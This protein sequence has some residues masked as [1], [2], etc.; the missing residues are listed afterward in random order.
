MTGSDPTRLRR[1]DCGERMTG[2]DPARLPRIDCGV[3]VLRPWRREDRDA[4]LRH[5]GDRSV[6]LNLRDTFPHP[7]T[8]ADADQWL[9]HA[10][11]DPPPPWT[12]AIDVG[13]EAVGTAALNRKDDV[14]RRSAELG[15]WVAEPFRGRG[16][17]TAAVRG[18]T[19]AALR[20]SDLV[21]VFAHV[22]A[23]NPTS[24]RVLEKAGF[25]REGVLERSAIKDGVLLDRVLFAVTHDPGL[26]YVPAPA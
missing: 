3:C 19:G 25:R 21:R 17:A 26:P 8:E 2:P 12:F 4:L 7:Y 18:I 6:W 13:G 9:A 1:I 5:A 22:F 16:I 10:A 11:A 14:E 15:Y 23:S 20:E 24:M